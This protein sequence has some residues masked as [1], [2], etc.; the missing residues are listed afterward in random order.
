LLKLHIEEQTFTLTGKKFVVVSMDYEE[1]ADGAADLVLKTFDK[2]E[3]VFEFTERVNDHT[4]PM[5]G[6]CIKS[7]SN[8]DFEQ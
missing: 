4:A 5:G 2:F 3:M 6:I 1:Q 7:Y 8:R